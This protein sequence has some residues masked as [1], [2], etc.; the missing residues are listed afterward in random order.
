MTSIRSVKRI[1]A[2]SVKPRKYPDMD[3]T[4]TPMVTLT[5]VTTRAIRIEYCVPR[6]T[7]ANTS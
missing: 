3:P 7:W 6:I 2:V 1:N 4:T 5:T